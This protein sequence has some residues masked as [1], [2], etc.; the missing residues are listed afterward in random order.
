MWSPHSRRPWCAL[1]GVGQERPASAC[2]EPPGTQHPGTGRRPPSRRL[3]GF[4]RGRGWGHSREDVQ[5][6]ALRTDGWTW[7][8]AARRL[9][10]L[11]ARPRVSVRWVHV[12]PL[13]RGTRG[14]DH[15]PEGRRCLVPPSPFP[16]R[17]SSTR[18]GGCCPLPE[19]NHGPPAFAGLTATFSSATQ[20]CLS[21]NRPQGQG[22]D[23]RKPDLGPSPRNA[24][25]LSPGDPRLET[26]L[27]ATT[28]RC[29]TPHDV[30][31]GPTS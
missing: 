10:R 9:Q 27:D 7:R 2:P 22:P 13:S 6:P 14:K 21:H 3:P 26:F 8:G 4:R 30:Q 12:A 18:S 20:C 31:M 23:K 25:V 16:G 1:G 28:R 24:G 17:G 11:I 29:S 15:G 5:P 19:G